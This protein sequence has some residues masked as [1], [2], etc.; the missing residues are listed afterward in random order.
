MILEQ[1]L[2][3][4]RLVPHQT[5][6]QEVHNLLRLAE[7]DIEDAKIKGLSV[8]RR[9]STAYNAVLQLATI[10]VY[11]EGYRAKGIAHHFTVFQAAK[12]I[13]GKNYHELSDYFDSCRAKRNITNYS[14]ADK[15]SEREAEE[16]LK[17]AEK[18]RNIVVKFIE[19]KHPKFLK[20]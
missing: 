16:L 9:F 11:C 13:M 4:G 18:F 2:N 7:R 15:I 20:D 12:E 3:Q 19:K 8:D 17:E 14:C 5:S 6:A 1:L 10:L